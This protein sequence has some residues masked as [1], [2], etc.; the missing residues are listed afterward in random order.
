MTDPYQRLA[1]AI[2]R[3]AMVDLQATDREVRQKAVAF[4][5]NS[6][7]LRSWCTLLDKDPA[8][9]IA[10]ISND[11]YSDVDDDQSVRLSRR[12]S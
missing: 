3:Q 8:G 1:V 7:S 12:V 5:N 6:P 4:L 11:I 9:A 2:I 10:A